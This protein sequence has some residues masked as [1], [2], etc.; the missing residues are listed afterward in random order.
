MDAAIGRVL[1]RLGAWGL[2]DDTVVMFTGD[3][4][5]DGFE[6]PWGD[7]QLAG[8]KT[9]VLEGGVRVPFV[10]SACGVACGA[11]GCRTDRVAS[12]VDLLRTIAEAAGIEGSLPGTGSAAVEGRSFW[13]AL[14]TQNPAAPTARDFAFAAEEMRRTKPGGK[15]VA[16]MTSAGY[17]TA[18][19]F[20]ESD[21]S[22]LSEANNAP[23]GICGYEG[24][25][26]STTR[27]HRV[28]GASCKKCTP[29]TNPDEDHAGCAAETCVVLGGRCLASWTDNEAT[30]QAAPRC[31]DQSDCNALGTTC[32]TDLTTDCNR[33]RPPAWKLLATLT[34]NPAAV[35]QVVGLY[36]LQSNPEE[37]DGEGALDLD[38]QDPGEF[39]KVKDELECT[40]E[41]WIGGV[42]PVQVEDGKLTVGPGFACTE[43]N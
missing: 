43:Q 14:N 24:E 36:D 34:P 18:A 15:R 9:D 13:D 20:H 21:N 22:G 19:T 35:A 40:V 10:A 12:H 42:G 30:L 6:A 31:T 27:Q 33:C 32:Y 26:I 16:I 5:Q 11:G 25:P 8:R 41:A 1:E 3:Q 23:N 39:P 29:G 7:P 4:G 38:C 28:R 2:T 17:A 37:Q